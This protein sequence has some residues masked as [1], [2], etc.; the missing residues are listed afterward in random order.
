MKEVTMYMLDNGELHEDQEKARQAELFLELVTL[1]DRNLQDDD[2]ESIARFISEH[3]EE[4]L[5]FL[6]NYKKAGKH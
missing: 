6:N 2:S 1:I 5:H 4:I 3:K